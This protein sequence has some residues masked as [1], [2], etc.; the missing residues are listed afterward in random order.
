MN[1]LIR[2]CTL[3][4]IVVLLGTKNVSAQ[5]CADTD[6]NNILKQIVTSVVTAEVIK[7]GSL[8]ENPDEKSKIVGMIDVSDKLEILE[9]K[10]T[11]WYR[12]YNPLSGDIGWLKNEYISI[13]DDE[14]SNKS[15]LNKKDIETFANMLQVQ[16]NADTLVWVDID[17]QLVY[18]LNKNQDLFELQKTIPC[19][20]G[21][22]ES[23]TPRGFFAIQERGVWFYSE[24]LKSGAKF[25][26]RFHGSYLFHSTP[27]N[28]SKEII[29]YT[30]GEKSSSGCVRLSLTDAEW[31]YNS[32]KDGTIVFIN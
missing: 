25:W 26:V 3:F 1:F 29:D 7:S 20:T 15:T 5:N 24:R 30:I 21:K 11:I 6:L 13:P 16:E 4:S 17:R 28:K 31:F 23:P 22:N 10:T 14:P 32:I 8:Y 27:M 12:V 19:S 18:I 2:M 9:D